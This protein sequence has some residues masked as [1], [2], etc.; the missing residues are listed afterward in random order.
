MAGTSQVPSYDAA[1]D[2]TRTTGI[3]A[4]DFVLASTRAGGLAAP[5]PRKTNRTLSSGASVRS[6]STVSAAMRR[7]DGVVISLRIGS[8]HSGSP[9]AV[10][11]KRN[12]RGSPRWFW[13]ATKNTSRPSL[14]RCRTWSQWSVLPSITSSVG[15]IFASPASTCWSCSGVGCSGNR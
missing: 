7:V 15:W 2:T 13:L 11:R 6:T 14:T 9:V 5:S 10:M 12:G 1:A 8:Q 3:V 4:T